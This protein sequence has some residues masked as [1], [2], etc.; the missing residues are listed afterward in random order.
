VL[1]QWGVHLFSLRIGFALW[2]WLFHKCALVRH[3]AP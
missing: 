1:G 3:T 2:A